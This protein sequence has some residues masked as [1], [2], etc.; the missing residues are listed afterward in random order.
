MGAKLCARALFENMS[1]AQEKEEMS[2]R[3]E[4]RKIERRFILQLH[5]SDLKR[6]EQFLF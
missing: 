2:A 3:Y 4:R 6:I 5:K 1:V